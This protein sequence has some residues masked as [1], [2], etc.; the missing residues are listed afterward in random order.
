MT[1]NATAVAYINNMGGSRSS[2]CND[3]AR[4]EWAW[5]MTRNIWLTASHIPGKLNVLPTRPPGCLMILQNGNWMLTY[6]R[7]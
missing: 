2:L 7:S 1:D 4:E 6:F 5:C 3:M